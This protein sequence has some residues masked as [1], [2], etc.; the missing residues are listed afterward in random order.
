MWVE[1]EHLEGVEEEV[2][3]RKEGGGGSRR[4]RAMRGFGVSG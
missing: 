2:E 4:C 3:V 1:R